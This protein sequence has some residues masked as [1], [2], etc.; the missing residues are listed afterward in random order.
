MFD[1][2]NILGNKYFKSKSLKTGE[3]LFDEGEIDKNIYVVE[4]GKVKVEKYF[5][6][7]K[8]EKKLLAVLGKNSIFGEG[9]IFNNHPKEVVISAIGET[10]LYF[11]KSKDFRNFVKENT[12]I[13]VD[14]LSQIINL[15][16]K[17]LLEANFLLTSNYKISK[18]ISEEIEFSN[19]NLFDIIDEFCSII[20]AK[21][22][23]YVEINQ[24]LENYA[25]VS[26]DSRIQ[27]KLLD[28]VVEL[29]NS[30]IDLENLKEFEVGEK[31]MILEL[32]NGNKIIGFFIIGEDEKVEFSESQ[33]KSIN[34]IGVLLAGF[35]KQKQYF[36]NEKNKEKA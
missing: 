33:K 28:K 27:G 22:I 18:M 12:E 9:S 26:Y 32:K 14:F 2:K 6:S 5:S 4:K 23:I 17:R 31:N 21:Y 36:Q 29:K 15:S 11:I 30:K 35:I 19:K 3:I 20:K 8:K 24:V 1:I 25:T 16:N 13:A 7:E 34:S 10:K